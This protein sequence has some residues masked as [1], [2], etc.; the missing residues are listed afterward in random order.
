MSIKLTIV[1]ALA[2]M[3]LLAAAPA[4]AEYGDT[5]KKVKARGSLS[6]TGHNGSYMGMAE[7]DDKGNWK[8]FDIDMCRAISTAIFGNWQGHLD[9]KPTS[10]AQRWPS[11]QSGEIDMVIKSSGWTFSRD[12]EIHGQFAMPY[13]MASIHYMVRKDSG[14]KTAKELDGGTLCLPTGT[15]ME[16]YVVDHEAANGYKIKVIPFEKTEESNAAFLAGRCDAMMEWDLQLGVVRATEAKNA[17]DYV[18]L[19]D[20]LSAE[21]VGIVMRQG[22]DNWVD[23]ANWVET[24]LLLAEQ[25]GVT[26]ANVDKMKAAPP[27]PAIAKLL[28]AAPG[29]GAP[30]GLDD[31]WAYNV[32][33][34][35]GN[36]SEMWDRN[37]GKD[38]PYKVA[39]GVNA[40]VRDGGILYPL[41]LD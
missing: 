25:N 11:L 18:I 9:I 36:S 3:A 4:H 26:S 33:K 17:D 15:T 32:I 12:T 7:V 16:R 23:I 14:I 34:T 29:M 1:T 20:V 28:G 38:S 40:L 10:W 2:S 35:V 19:P 39:R 24:A 6:C 31:N 22:D 8:G 27:S 37:I 41:V 21:P 13:M 5:L 30:L